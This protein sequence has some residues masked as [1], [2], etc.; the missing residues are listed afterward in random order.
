MPER[1]CLIHVGTHKTG[2]TA[3]QNLV[4]RS[5]LEF[6]RIGLWLCESGA[7]GTA[8]HNLAWELAAGNFSASVVDLREELR[9]NPVH[10]AIFSSEDLSLLHRDPTTLRRLADVIRDAGYTPKFLVYLRAQATYAES[11]YSERIKHQDIRFLADILSEIIERG[12]YVTKNG[13][14]VPFRYT[15]LLDRLVEAAGPRGVLARPYPPV[16]DADNAIYHDFVASINHLIPTLPP[17]PLNLSVIKVRPNESLTFGELLFAAF[18]GL[19]ENIDYDLIGQ[20]EVDPEPFRNAFVPEV[21]RSDFDARFTLLSREERVEVAMA[22]A[23]DNN[24]V[25][26]RFGITIPNADVASIPPEGDPR[27]DLAGTERHALTR[28]LRLWFKQKA[29]AL[30]PQE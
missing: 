23:E 13:L 17:E 10:H 2:S 14:R 29:E 8:N 1:V 4:E 27:W 5:R 16:G 30:P 15:A 21:S 22:F 3:L 25:R 26:Q 28:L 12:T 24:L 18:A 11:L 7:L 6:L 19:I 20:P 9:R